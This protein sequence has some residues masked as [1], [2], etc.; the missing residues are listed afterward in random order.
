MAI[1]LNDNS[2]SA[3][4]VTK[5]AEGGAYTSEAEGSYGTALSAANEA[6]QAQ[7][8]AEAA[9]VAAE[10]AQTAAE[11][12]ETNAETAETN[13]ETAETNAETAET[14]AQASAS[15]ASTSETNAATSESNAATSA[16]NA[17][18]S[19]NNA[20][21][22][23]TNAATSASNASTSETNAS[24][25]A[26]AALTSE[27]NAATSETNAATSA[28]AALTSENNAATSE[29]NAATSASNALT[30][31]NNA[32]T[33]ESNASTSEANALTSANNASTSESNASTSETNASNSAIAAASAKT[34]A[35]SARDATLQA[36]DNFDDRYLGAKASDPTTDNDGDP[37]IAGSLYFDTTNEVMKLY[38]GST[39]V[40]AYADFSNVDTDSLAEGDVNL[41][42]TDTRAN[43]AIDTRVNKTF[44]DALNV[45]ADTLDGIDSTGFATSAQGS[46]A[47]SAIQP[48]DNISELTND[49]NYTV[50]G[51]AVTFSSVQFTGGTGNQGTVSWNTDEETLDLIENGTILQIGQELHYNVRNNTGSTILNGTP[52]YATGTIGNSGRITIAPYIANG[53]ISAKFFLG[54]T[55]EDIANDTDGKVTQ[56]GKVRDL[57]TSAYNDGDVL[58]VSPTTAGAL[59]STEPTGSN[60]NLSVAFVIHAHA[61]GTLFVRSNNL[62]KNEF[63]TAAQGTNA[64]TAYSWGDHN[65]LYD[66]AGTAVALAI[67]LG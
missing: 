51:T 14:N 56:F 25:S 62:N 19:A 1:E 46:L 52:V 20:S 60:I 16:S 33:S 3:G 64:D 15:A 53:S 10:A 32:A 37:L 39:W 12:A 24:N 48:N 8:A 18:T 9:Q 2:T 61:S 28:S 49:S 47:D 66:P 22:S 34:A 58:Y 50:D 65:G 44:V 30:S 7:L 42:Y 17:L 11:L 38:T 35:E 36:Y 13:A 31:A 40:I 45:D 26:S 67:A 43:T 54:I 21:T 41:Y 5:K 55:T 27:N 4:L 63:A 29:T 23:E 6:I 59:T 57:N